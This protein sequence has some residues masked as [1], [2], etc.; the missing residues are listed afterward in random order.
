MLLVA[1]T[2]GYVAPVV[3]VGATASAGA[4]ALAR[5]AQQFEWVNVAAGGALVGLG[6]YGALDALF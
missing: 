4:A 6:T 2:A 3:A 1:F 5:K